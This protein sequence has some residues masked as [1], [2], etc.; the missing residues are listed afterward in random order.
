MPVTVSGVQGGY[1]LWTSGKELLQTLSLPGLQDVA[2]KS[3][4]DALAQMAKI[5][6]RSQTTTALAPKTSTSS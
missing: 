5:V 2:A 6:T 1:C 3:T 4:I